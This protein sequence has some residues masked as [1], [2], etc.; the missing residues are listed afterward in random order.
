VICFLSIDQ[1]GS[2]IL[3]R[4]EGQAFAKRNEQVTGLVVRAED[5]ERYPFGSVEIL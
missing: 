5:V 2:N 1:D 3:A 4:H